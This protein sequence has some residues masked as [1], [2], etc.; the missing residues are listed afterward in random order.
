MG[1][2]ENHV[3]RLHCPRRSIRS[4]EKVKTLPSKTE[5]LQIPIWLIQTLKHGKVS[6]QTNGT[7]KLL[8]QVENNTMDL[9]FLQKD[10]IKDTL[11]LKAEM[12][13][14]SILKALETLKNPAEK[15]KQDGFTITISHKGQTVLTLGSGAHPT[16][17]QMVRGTKAI[18]INNLIELIK[19]VK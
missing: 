17:S 16:I 18:E 6:L 7:E 14:E 2:N 15:L 8:V 19:L 10:L 1:W 4:G 5:L 12:Q 3:E 9:N 13:K 11:E